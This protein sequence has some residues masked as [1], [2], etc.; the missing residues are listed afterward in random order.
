MTIVHGLADV[1][2]SG[3][4]SDDC[5]RAPQGSS[6]RSG[7]PGI[8]DNTR[9]SQA[10]PISTQ[11]HRRQTTSHSSIRDPSEKLQATIA[12]PLG[13]LISC[14][15]GSD[16]NGKPTSQ[17]R[18]ASGVHGSLLF[19]RAVASPRHYPTSRLLITV[20]ESRMGGSSVQLHAY[21]SL[22]SHHSLIQHERKT[23]SLLP[24][25]KHVS[26]NNLAHAFDTMSHDNNLAWRSELSQ[27]LCS[28]IGAACADGETRT[29]RGMVIIMLSSC[30]IRFRVLH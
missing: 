16:N 19:L 28:N 1:S 27:E 30:Q 24:G 10:T 8:F 23:H 7:K 2:A 12:S 3:A 9:Q 6:S 25:A 13:V 20:V 22:P 5:A 4:T 26:Y 17:Q 14:P 11:R 18:G 29:Y 21:P 15:I